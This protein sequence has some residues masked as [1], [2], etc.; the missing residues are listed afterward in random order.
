MSKKSLKGFIKTRHFI[1]RQKERNVSDKD[2]IRAIREG[3]LSR[4][5]YGQNFVLGE[6]KVT[7]DHHQEILITVHPGEAPMKM[8][9]LL[10]SSEAG[11]IKEMIA[12]FERNKRSDEDET[13]EFLKF[14][15][16]NAVKK[17]K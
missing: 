14:V 10:T 1:E 3:K 17:L 5:D 8:T 15:K 6:L 11:I 2:V 4:N 7:I 12:E 16:E 9:K 13:D